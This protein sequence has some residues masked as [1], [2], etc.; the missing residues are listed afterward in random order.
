MIPSV[1]T[2]IHNH[3]A[4][5]PRP[6]LIVGKGPTAAR[7]FEVDVAK[8]HVLTLNHACLLVY[9]TLAHFVDIEAY[10]D[11][12]K[13]LA[14]MT[15]ATVCLPWHPHVRHK[16]AK[17]D[18]GDYGIPTRRLVSY[19]ATTA[20]KLP[21]MPGLPTIRLHYFSSVAAFNILGYAGIREVHSLGVDG[22]TEYAEMFDAK[23]KLANGRQSFDKQFGEIAFAVKRH[24]IKWTKL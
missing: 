22:G 2:H 11:C 17:P 9:P 3:T 7:I 4:A 14:E 1:I 12:D 6:W 18:L 13:K 16:A 19:N 8:Y 10:R 15:K 24:K 20:G 23:D 5:H 21:R